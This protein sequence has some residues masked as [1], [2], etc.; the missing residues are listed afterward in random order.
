MS[1]VRSSRAG[2]TS[3]LYWMNS[4]PAREVRQLGCRQVVRQRVLIPPYGGSNPSTPA[5]IVG[6]RYRSRRETPGPSDDGKDN[7]RR[8]RS[9]AVTNQSARR[10]PT[11]QALARVNARRRPRRGE[12]AGRIIQPPG[13]NCSARVVRRVADKPATQ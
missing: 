1:G 11:I 13:Q 6:A 5:N 12:A 9:F 7:A 2:W 4:A 10:G 8:A 3:L